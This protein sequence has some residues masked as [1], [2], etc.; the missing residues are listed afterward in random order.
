MVL[1]VALCSTLLVGQVA[2]GSPEGGCSDGYDRDF[3]S[4]ECVLAD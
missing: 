4:G 1:V 2:A 3:A